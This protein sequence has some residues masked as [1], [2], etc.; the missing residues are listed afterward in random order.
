MHRVHQWLQSTLR[1]L[2]HPVNLVHPVVQV[3]R[4]DQDCP[5]IRF[6]HLFLE[7]PDFL[8]YLEDPKEILNCKIFTYLILNV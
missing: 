3:A 8:K 6:D 4:L 2:C 5:A 1:V 7:H